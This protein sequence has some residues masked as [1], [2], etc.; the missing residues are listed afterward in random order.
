MISDKLLEIK[1]YNGYEYS[2]VVDYDTWRVAILNYAD[3]LLPDNIQ[4]MQRHDETDEVFI[5]LSGKCILFIG[6]GNDN[7]T[8]VHA[9]DM[10]PFKVYNVKKG[11][12]HNHSLSKDGKVLIVENVDTEDDK[13]SP[14]IELPKK[15]IDYI[16]GIGNKLL[17]L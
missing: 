15:D 16:R 1:E 3:S 6:D 17:S 13:N 7:V 8:A 9:I 14:Y 11:A 4:K 12:W 5:L 2:P 10:L